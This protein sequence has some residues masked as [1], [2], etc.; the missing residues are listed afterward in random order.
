MRWVALVVALVPG[1]LLAQETNWLKNPGFEA[2]KSATAPQDWGYTDF[3]T[4]GK[5]LYS[6]QAG[7]G[8]SAAVGIESAD[9]KQRGAWQQRLELK[10]GR[11]L[12]VQGWY[13]T[14]GLK[15]S[16]GNGAT[17]RMTY[18]RETA[19]W[20]FIRDQ[21]AYLPP[22]E[23]WAPVRALF[24]AP[25][26]AKV[27]VIELFNFFVPGKVWWDDM[28]VR[29]ASEDEIREQ[30]AKALDA[31]P[32]ANQLP[33]RPADGA[34]SSVNPPSFVWVPVE[35]TQSYIL[36]YSRSEDFDDRQTVT[37]RDIKLSIYTP[38]EVWQPGTYYWRYG[39]EYEPGKP[40][41]S[42]TWRVEVPAEAQDFPRPRTDQV[43]ARISKDRPRV[44]FS[45]AELEKIRTDPKYAKDRESAARGAERYLGQDLYPEP[46][47]LA[48]DRE[49]RSK[50]YL[51]SFRTMRPW[52]RGMENCARA[53]VLTGDVRFAQEAKRRLLH[54][55]TWDVDGPTSVFHNDEAAM[56]IAMRGPRT[57]DWIYDT[58]TEQE[59]KTCQE[60]LRARLAQIH[61]LHLRM[62]FHSKPYSS[63][64]GRMIGFSGEGAI[65]FA[66]EEPEAREWLD[67]ILKVLWAVYPAWGSDDGGWHE[68]PGYWNAYMSMIFQFI[69]LLDDIGVPYKDKPFL[70]NTGWFGFYDVCP[71]AQQRPFGD[72]H[73][74]SSGRGDGTLLY[75]FSRLYHNPYFRWYAETLGVHQ[76]GGPNGFLR[77]EDGLKAKPPVD[78]PQARCFPHV[79]IVA[80]Y[81]DA[82]RPK[83]TIHFL[84]KSDPYGS[85]SHNHASQNA[86]T[87]SAF[88]EALAIS[89][90]YY[91]RYGC[92]HHAG[93]TWET[94]AHNSILVD[95]QG[96][97]KR[98]ADSK[99]R[100][101]HFVNMPEFCYTAGDAT[102]AYEG[103]L[104]KFV[105]HVLFVRPEY[106]VMVDELESAGESDY[107]WLLHAKSEMKLDEAAQRVTVAQ[108][109]ARMRV[110]FLAPEGLKFSQTDQFDV[111]PE[112]PDSPNQWHFRASTPS[113]SAQAVFVTVLTPYREGRESRVPEA[114][115][116]PAQGGV[117]VELRGPEGVDLALWRL[118]A[119][120]ARVEA[121]DVSSEAAVTCVRRSADGTVRSVFTY[122]GKGLTVAGR[123]V[124]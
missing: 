41:F 23:D 5:A 37:V 29:P 87:V 46:K 106:F 104:K 6:R 118:A 22:S 14:E 7:R 113:K 70:Q 119:G 43:L 78:I 84:F 112:K 124:D 52:T 55:A 97:K 115:L 11:V 49:E 38:H 95:G 42:R 12:M 99:G 36:Q 54:F 122:G 88:G 18:L 80:M 89:S 63:H 77:R 44:Y 24:R 2:A 13:R 74:G 120:A 75:T 48:S 114:K 100:I 17:V 34:K 82:S 57:F 91:Q 116:L 28:E 123:A 9:E 67:Y 3:R 68:G 117:A 76:P 72:G 73:E 51:E 16:R 19:G 101:V 103:R 61:Q 62:P 30:A 26:E 71:F 35:G 110:Q 107:Q 39:F 69:G 8:G 45:R 58:L 105:R 108:G 10:V 4:G 15:P 93:W 111:P 109:Q 90:G 31:E 98:S 66:H 79:G 86:F 1:A 92:P 47:P 25:P 33:R 94:K 59:R 50:Q 102:A 32:A 60:M 85:I 64:P 27:V 83:E 121:A 20:D 81:S 21:R 40:V 65:V 96:Q 53:Y 56:D